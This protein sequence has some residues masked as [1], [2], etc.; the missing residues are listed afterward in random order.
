MDIGEPGPIW[1]VEELNELLRVGPCKEPRDWMH[2][3]H[4]CKVIRHEDEEFRGEDR[5][6][7]PHVPPCCPQHRLT[8]PLLPANIDI[9]EAFSLVVQRAL[10]NEAHL[11]GGVSTIEDHIPTSKNLRPDGSLADPMHHDHH[12]LF[13]VLEEGVRGQ[14]LRIDFASE[15]LLERLRQQG[16]NANAARLHHL[17]PLVALKLE[18]FEDTLLQ[19]L[20][21]ILLAHVLPE[22]PELLHALANDVPQACHGTCDACH[23]R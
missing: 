18:E 2:S 12:L 5:I 3:H 9:D 13:H 21:Y 4:L 23:H 1:V 15:A 10:N 16:E 8:H 19:V 11:R 14:V 17:L 7:L 6:E 22:S 20:G